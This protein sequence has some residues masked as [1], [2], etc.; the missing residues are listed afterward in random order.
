MISFGGSRDFLSKDHE[1]YVR[2]YTLKDSDLIHTAC[3]KPPSNF[4][5]DL[6]SVKLTVGTTV[7]FA[8]NTTQNS[9][10]R[11]L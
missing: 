9:N 6:Y 3:L 2:R 10:S 11:R 5:D 7:E 4:Y 1:I 8:T